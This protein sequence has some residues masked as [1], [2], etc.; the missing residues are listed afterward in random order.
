MTA[1]PDPSALPGVDVVLPHRAPSVSWPTLAWPTAE[2]PDVDRLDDILSVA[3]DHNPNRD[4]ALSLACVVVHRG[5]VVGERY[6]PGTSARTPLLSWSVAKSVTQLAV[7]AG[8]RK[9]LVDLE[10]VPVAPEWNDPSDPRHGI[11]LVDLLQMRDGLDFVEDYTE[12]GTCN[13]LDM[14]FGAGAG[15]VAAYAAA[16]PVAEAPGAC[17][18]YSSGSTNIISRFLTTALGGTDAMEGFLADEVLGPIGVVGADAR[19]DD[20]GTWVGSSYLYLTARDFARIGELALRDGVW[21]G[22]RILPEGWIDRARTA[23]SFDPDDGLY[24]GEHWWIYGDEWGTFAA[25]GYEGQAILVVP[26][27]DLVIAR[28][29]KTPSEHKPALEAWYRDVIDCFAPQEGS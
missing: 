22:R 15:D 14:L 26:G 19:V 23:V 12:I 6:G 7:G 10:A 20:A 27:L 2:A 17:F 25:K 1:T 5:R 9:G 24:Y 29:G 13:C 11:T 3:F 4:L 18:N 21:N 16:R 8:V 28:F